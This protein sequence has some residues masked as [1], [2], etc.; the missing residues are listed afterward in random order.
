MD[1]QR[2]GAAV[3]AFVRANATSAG[4]AALC[5][6]FFGFYVLADPTGTTG[7]ARA[8]WVYLYTLRIGGIAMAVIAVWSLLGHR[9]AL[10]VDAVASLLIGGLLIVSA[11][12][13]KY[14]GWDMVNTVI[15]VICGG[16]FVSSGVRNGRLYAGFASVHRAQAT[17]DALL[18][19]AVGAPPAERPGPVDARATLERLR[20]IREGEASHAAPV[21]PPTQ[22]VRHAEP[23]PEARPVPHRHTSSAPPHSDVRAPAA[24]T[25]TPAPD[26]PAPEGFLA[27]FARKRDD[28]G[29]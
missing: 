25:V 23:S 4:L 6:L 3:A 21:E 19:A 14:L 8:N 2:R 22:G 27:S 10:A 13:L 15:S 24:P 26:E 5:L 7:F 20:R 16:M 1:T 28:Q 18:P 11:L 17:L 29:D 12:V 9:V